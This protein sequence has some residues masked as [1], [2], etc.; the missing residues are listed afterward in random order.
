MIAFLIV[1]EF[2]TAPLM[3][4]VPA[5]VIALAFVPP[6]NVNEPALA[7]EPVR[8][9]AFDVNDLPEFTTILFTI[10]PVLVT[11]PLM[12]V[13]P[14]VVPFALIAFAFVPSDRINDPAFAMPD[15][16]TRF[17]EA[18]NVAPL[19]ILITPWLNV[20]ATVVV[21]PVTFVVPVPVKP[22]AIVFVPD[23]FNVPAFKI[24]AVFPLNVILANVKVL[25]EDTLNA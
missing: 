24:S 25:P 7:I 16:A 2:V 20:P 12:Y 8:F 19:D 22:L 3:Y 5:P 18:D 6:V 10:V 4:V 15:V 23:I 21:P 14:V 11:A 9:P 17:A 1:P 13:V